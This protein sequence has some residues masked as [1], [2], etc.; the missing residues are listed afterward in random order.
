MELQVPVLLRI[1]YHPLAF[2]FLPALYLYVLQIHLAEGLYEC[3]GEARVGYKRYVMVY[4]AAAYE[5]AVAQ[6]TV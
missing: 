6:F 3:A 4:S 2:V 1:V 5:V